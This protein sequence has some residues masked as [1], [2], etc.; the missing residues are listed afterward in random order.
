MQTTLPMLGDDATQR[1]LYDP[2]K[3]DADVGFG[4]LR[5]ERGSL[6]LIEMAV[7]ARLEGLAASVEVRQVFVNSHEQALE[8][9]YVFPLPDRA[10]VTSFRLEVA[11]R[12]IE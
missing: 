1:S 9:T 6:P 10:A 4:A 11:G 8:A 5:T 3:P 7:A 12:I 2:A